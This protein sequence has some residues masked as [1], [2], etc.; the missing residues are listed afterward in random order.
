MQF[1]VASLDDLASA[2]TALHKRSG[3][4]VRAVSLQTKIN[5]GTLKNWMLGKHWPRL[6]TFSALVAFYGATVT[7][8]FKPLA[9]ES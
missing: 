9:K 6:D 1:H 2:L 5:Q 7:V 3:L 8:G 4:S